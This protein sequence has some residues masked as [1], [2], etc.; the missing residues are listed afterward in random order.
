MNASPTRFFVG[1]D[2]GQPQELTALAVLQR[3]DSSPATCAVRH[4]RRWP[5]G[6]SYPAIITEVSNVVRALAPTPTLVVDQTAVGRPVVQLLRA[7]GLR[8][9][10]YAVTITAGHSVAGDADSVHVP[11]K[12][13][14]SVLQVLLQYRRLKVASSL[15]EA[16]TL[17][18][19]LTAFQAKVTLTANDPAAPWRD[20]PHDDL[21]LAVALGAWLA[22]NRIEPYT[23]PLVYWPDVRRGPEDP[24]RPKSCLQQVCEELGIDLDAD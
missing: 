12:E 20:G 17:M 2:L 15:A 9:P 22:E 3:A 1:L 18:R 21:V 7:A 4:L 10:L 23:G 16:A 6:T 14:V 11:K 24:E 8:C 13:L 5:V 19:E